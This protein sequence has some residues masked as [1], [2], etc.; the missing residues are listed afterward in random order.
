[1]SL[2]SIQ[3]LEFISFFSP[4]QGRMANTTTSVYE[5]DSIVTGLT[6]TVRLLRFWLDQ[7][8]RGK[9]KFP[10]LQKQVIN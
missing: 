1:M 4:L 6:K 8:S 3:T 10:F 9:N 2:A 5:I 7:F